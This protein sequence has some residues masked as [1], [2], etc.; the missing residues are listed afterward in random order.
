MEMGII[1]M[2]GKDKRELDFETELSGSLYPPTRII[3]YTTRTIMRT[4]QQRESETHTFKKIGTS[5]ASFFFPNLEIFLFLLTML[6][7]WAVLLLTPRPL[8]FSMVIR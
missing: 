7:V 1:L 8:T 5:G 4:Q 6:P 3:T 2:T